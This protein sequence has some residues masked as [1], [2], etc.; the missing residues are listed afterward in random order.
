EESEVWTI[1]EGGQA[2]DAIFRNE[3]PEFKTKHPM[4]FRRLWIKVLFKP[5][6]MIA[7]NCSCGGRTCWSRPGRR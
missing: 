6:L 3:S 7:M 2:A 4:F 5:L 1:K